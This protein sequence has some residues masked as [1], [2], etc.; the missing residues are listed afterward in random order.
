MILLYI[1]KDINKEEI[2]ISENIDPFEF[3][4]YEFLESVIQNEIEWE[5]DYTE[6]T[7]D[8]Y[9]FWFLT[10]A[11]TRIYKAIAGKI[12]ITINGEVFP[13]VVNNVEEFRI[14]QILGVLE[15]KHIYSMSYGKEFL[16]F[17]SS[18]K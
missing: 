10:D 6:A 5:F 4:D 17:Y 7:N 15:D 8:E 11:V 12:P 9:F 1:I 13:I 14:S 3:L 18:S 2:Y 16:A